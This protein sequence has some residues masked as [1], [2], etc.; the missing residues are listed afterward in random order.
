MICHDKTFFKK[1][2]NYYFVTEFQNTRS[3]HEHGL[4][5]IEYAPIYGRDSDLEIVNFLDMYITCNKDHLNLD[6]VKFHRNF[7]TRSYKKQNN[8]HCI[9]NFHMPPMKMAMIL[10]PTNSPYKALD[11]KSKFIFLS[12]EKKKP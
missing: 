6:F 3:G 10:E 8:S 1:V 2:S 7:H 12:L 9:Y 5:W 4:L 11:E